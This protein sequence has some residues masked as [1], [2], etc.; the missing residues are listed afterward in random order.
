MDV[1][2]WLYRYQ[3]LE[4][5]NGKIIVE[6]F[7]KHFLDRYLIRDLINTFPTCHK[8]VQVYLGE[9]EHEYVY[10]VYFEAWRYDCYYT[11]DKVCTKTVRKDWHM[12]NLYW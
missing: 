11:Y 3:M 1:I 4:F 7:F 5:K 6:V 9:R 12:F 10:E 2:N 8:I